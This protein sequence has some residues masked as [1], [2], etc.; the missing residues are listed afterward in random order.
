MQ[1]KRTGVILNTENFDACVAFYRD[2]FGLG[3]LF[4]RHDDDFRLSCLD[5][6]DGSYL[7]IETEGVARP[8]GK[9]LA[10]NAAKLRFH[11]DDIDAAYRRLM[12]FGIDAELKRCSWGTTIN[13]YDPDGNRVGLRCEREFMAGLAADQ[14]TLR[15]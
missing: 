12:S 8:S 15:R 2:V 6:G 5:V 11:V 13:C 4:T 1:L 10:E 3:V 9:S 14:D 7:M